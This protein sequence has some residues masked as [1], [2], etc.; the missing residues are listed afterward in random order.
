[1][2]ACVI[3]S[4]CGRKGPPLPPLVKLPVAPTEVTAARRG[5]TVDLQL[6]VPST[7][8]DASRPAN[9]ARVEVYALTAPAS[10]PDAEVLRRGMKVAS[11]DVKSPRDPQATTDPDDEEDADADV[12]PPEGSG[13][14]QGAVARVQEMLSNAVRSAGAAE[15]RRDGG[16][17]AGPLLGPLP[18]SAASR[19]Y[20]GV[21]VTTKGRRGPTSRR[22]VVPLIPPPAAPPKPDVNYD[23]SAITVSWTAGAAAAR[24]QEPATG[25]ILQSRPIGNAVP[26]FAYHVYEV[27]PP[28][29]TVAGVRAATAAASGIDA[30]L[31]RAPVTDTRFSDPRVVWGA[32]RCYAVRRVQIVDTLSIE[33]E[34]SPA[35]CVTMVDTFPPAAPKGLNAVAS[36]EGAINLIWDANGERDLDGYIVLRASLPNAMLV[37]ITPMP[38]HETGFRD[39]GEPGVK[40]TYAVQAVDQAGNL[41]AMSERI[42][43]TAR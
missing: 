42:E 43:E 15:V 38:I 8:T 20:V 25:T 33:S 36:G 27:P 11:V 30:Q 34:R 26:T 23:E 17:A 35:T 24:L 41:S 10:T 14:D 6:T 22:V 16:D 29:A 7:N 40:Y 21:A 9:V 2:F 37:R 19:I 39:T 31:T 32:T 3:M 12:E 4:A 28:A 5:D 13:L 1:M 18:A